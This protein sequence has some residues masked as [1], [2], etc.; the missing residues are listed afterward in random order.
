MQLN[1]LHENMGAL[2]GDVHKKKIDTKPYM[3]HW[4]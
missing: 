2:L 1:I 3:R 4:H